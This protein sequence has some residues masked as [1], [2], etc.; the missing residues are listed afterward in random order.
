MQWWWSTRPELKGRSVL[1]QL[2]RFRDF[3]FYLFG[4]IAGGGAAVITITEALRILAQSGQ[5]NICSSL[6]VKTLVN[7]VL[8]SNPPVG[9]ISQHDEGKWHMCSLRDACRNR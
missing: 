1:Y 4:I 7:M 6:L 9:D 2:L 8:G 3:I 5:Q